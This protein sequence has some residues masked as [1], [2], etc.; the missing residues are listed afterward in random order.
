MEL[1]HRLANIAT[2]QLS[3]IWI[4]GSSQ[5]PNVVSL[6]LEF[7]VKVDV[8]DVDSS[9]HVCQISNFTLGSRTYHGQSRRKNRLQG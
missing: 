3:A 6:L 2:E 9:Y 8:D 1:T 4:L 7:L 5:L